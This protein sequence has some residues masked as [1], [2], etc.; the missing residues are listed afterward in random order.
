ME[1]NP[2]INLRTKHTATHHRFTRKK[3][4]EGE[5]RLIL[6]PSLDPEG[7]IYSKHIH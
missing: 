4:K 6:V 7:E 1:K 5:I 2:D 3:I